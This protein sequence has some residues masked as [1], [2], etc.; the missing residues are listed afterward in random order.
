M[1]RQFDAWD[2]EYNF[3]MMSETFMQDFDGRSDLLLLS[4]DGV[5]QISYHK[6][7][8]SDNLCSA[9]VKASLIPFDF[10]IS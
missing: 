8:N 6:Y 5:L 4:P 3:M 9:E 7:G 2:D 10:Y 1:Q